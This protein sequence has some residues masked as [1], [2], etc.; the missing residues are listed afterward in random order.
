MSSSD[1]VSAFAEGT[2]EEQLQEL[3]E[4]TARGI[5][6]EDRTVLLQSLQDVV[7]TGNAPLDEDPRRTA[8]ELVL[9]NTKSMGKGTDHEIEGFFNLLYSHLFTLWQVDSSET[10]QHVVYLLN[11][12]SSSPSNNTSVKHRILSNL[13]NAATRSSALRLPIYT[14]LLQLAA[15]GG[16]LEVLAMTKSDVQRWLNEWHIS[17]E[18]K[19]QFLKTIIDTLTRAGKADSAYEYQI[20]LVHALPSSSPQGRSAAVDTIAAALRIPTVFDFDTLY[21]LDPIIAVRDHELFPLLQIF[22]RN[23]LP[24]FQ[25]WADGHTAVFE[26]YQLERSQLERK[27]RLLA[28]TSL[29]FDYIGRDL[30]YSTIASTLQIDTS[31]VEKWAIDVIRVGLIS[32]KLSQTTQNLHVHRS[33]A[34]KFEREQWEALEKRLLAWKAGL[35][36]VIEVVAQ[37]QRRGGNVAEALQAT[38]NEQGIQ[39]ESTA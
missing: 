14:T 21:N 39:V 31:Q 9:K 28:F 32:G 3:L 18:E 2:F 19:S 1:S 22:L 37:A 12:I 25:A 29:A 11:V 8:F 15:A 7:K 16:E 13:F 20:L 38:Q 36:S 23:G 27:I 33:S 10:R 5:P 30:P 26:I 34:R 4:Y 6:D 35:A 24:E 17:D